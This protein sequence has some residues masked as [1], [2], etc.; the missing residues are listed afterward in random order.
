MGATVL[1]RLV[2]LTL[3]LVALSVA[4]AT[5]A[6]PKQGPWLGLAG[7]KVGDFKW[8]VETKRPDG[9][10]GAGHLARRRPCLLVGATWQVSPFDLRR[11]RSRQCASASG[12]SPSGPPLVAKGVQSGGQG[13]ITAV[14][15]MFAPAVRR[16]RATFAGGKTKTI[17]LSELTPVE[18]REAGLARFRYA[19]FATRG[20]WC[21]ERLVGQSA[22]GK[23]LWDSGVDGY[24]CGAT[25]P[26]RFA[27][28]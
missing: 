5:A 28:N 25:G 21:A 6:A 15:M 10:A 4:P 1:K 2:L 18:A 13:T 16:V 12:L 26:P 19:A 23:T 7:G 14:G 27:S 11:S 8:S 9:A 24:T 22:S 20:E 3:C 17:H